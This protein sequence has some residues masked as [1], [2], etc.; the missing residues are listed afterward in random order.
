MHSRLQPPSSL[1]CVPGRFGAAHMAGSAFELISGNAEA[2]GV[3][4]LDLPRARRP[5]RRPTGLRAPPSSPPRI[6]RK[7]GLRPCAGTSGS[8]TVVW[9]LSSKSSLCQHHSPTLP[10]KPN[11][12]GRFCPT[13]CVRCPEFP[14][15]HA[16]WPSFPESFPNLSRIALPPGTS[17][18]TP[19]PLAGDS[20]HPQTGYPGRIDRMSSTPPARS[21]CGGYWLWRILARP[22]IQA[23]KFWPR[24]PSTNSPVPRST[25]LA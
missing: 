19:L 6:N 24:S 3:P 14:F 2:G 18:P 12:F 23:G 5:P 13:W 7:Q 8:E 15:H 20:R 10:C 9:P 25:Q 16:F 22:V 1:C 11:A 4:P 17:T 21:A